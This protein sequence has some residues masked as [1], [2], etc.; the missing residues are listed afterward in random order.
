MASSKLCFA[1]DST[2]AIIALNGLVRSLVAK[3]HDVFF[4]LD[5]SVVPQTFGFMHGTHIRFWVYSN[6]NERHERITKLEGHGYEVHILGRSIRWEAV[7]DSWDLSPGV[8]YDGMSARRDVSR[9]ND[10]LEKVCDTYG[11]S[12]IVCEGPV[13]FSKIPRGIPHLTLT[14]TSIL[15]MCGILNEAMYLHSTGGPLMVLAD[16]LDLKCKRVYHGKRDGCTFPYRHTEFI[17]Y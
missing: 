9:E 7:Y 14:Y 13:D 6:A 12:Y 16:V 5:I 3:E 17:E 11:Q 10:H 1:L 15:D 2:E 8:M 4:L